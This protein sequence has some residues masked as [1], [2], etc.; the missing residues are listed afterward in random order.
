[1]KGP[2]TTSGLMTRS[3]A[4]APENKKQ[5]R[6]KANPVDRE[7]E[8]RTRHTVIEEKSKSTP[9][10]TGVVESEA[11]RTRVPELP[12][13]G[14][15]S[16]TTVTR[17]PTEETQLA[18]EKTGPAYKNRAPVEEEADPETVLEEILDLSVSVPL[19]SLLGNAPSIREALK[20]NIT[21]A[22]R[23]PS[24]S[25]ATFNIFLLA[26]PDNA[27]NLSAEHKVCGDKFLQLYQ[28][29]ESLP[30]ATYTGEESAA[31]RSVYPKIN[32][33][34]QEEAILD[35]GSQI[36]S[37]AETVAT[38]MGLCWD[39]N[40]TI[41]MQSANKSVDRTLGLAKNVP[42]RFG[43]ITLYLQVHILRNP[44]YTILLGKNFDNLTRSQV[45][46]ERDGSTMLTLEDPN[47]RKRVVVP[48]YPRGKV[49]R[50]DNNDEK[51]KAF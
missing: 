48:T 18:A 41:N 21:K 25:E 39:P 36:V 43:D 2:R 8:P 19:K 17:K 32:G 22:R 24:K 3:R 23:A 20:K 10:E 50:E 49:P 12:F 46:N 38:R 14:V 51:T 29:G 13:L 15:P 42:F 47:S 37:M 31:L 40:I 33:V 4:K 26:G 6:F 5:A 1:M 27:H 30:E 16:L 28:D 45:Q 9:K 34:A 7:I 44:A 11:P 35:S